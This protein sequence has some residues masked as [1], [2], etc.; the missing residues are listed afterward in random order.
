MQKPS[1]RWLIVFAGL[2]AFVGILVYARSV[3]AVKCDNAAYS[4][5]GVCT[6]TPT[7]YDAPFSALRFRR[8]TTNQIVDVLTVSTTCNIAAVNTNS[9]A[10]E[11]GSG[12]LGE[13][14][15]DAIIFEMFTSTTVSGSA[16]LGDGSGRTCSA[17]NLPKE[18]D[19]PSGAVPGLMFETAAGVIKVT[20]TED[21]AP[22]FFPIDIA[23]G[24]KLTVTVTFNIGD[25]MS[26]TCEAAPGA[27]PAGLGGLSMGFEFTIE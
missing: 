12:T 13:G 4:G 9:T 18:F 6:V 25:G 8:Q 17:T 21:A 24:K 11:A 23:R 27:C 26:C 14:T 1:S 20:V 16:S 3:E 22:D 15:Y 19:L 10:C 7:R 5:E 2:L